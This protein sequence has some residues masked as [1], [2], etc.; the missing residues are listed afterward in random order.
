MGGP[1]GF[2]AVQVSQTWDVGMAS[3]SVLV[4]HQLHYPYYIFLSKIS[5]KFYSFITI[6]KKLI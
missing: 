5:G 6:D 1:K 4:D 3:P 2:F